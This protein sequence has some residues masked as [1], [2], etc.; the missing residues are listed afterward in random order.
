MLSN[1][2]STLALISTNSNAA[3]VPVNSRYLVTSFFKGWLT[4]TSAGGGTATW[5]FSLQPR[6]LMEARA[7]KIETP[8]NLMAVMIQT[9]NLLRAY[10]Q[11]GVDQAME[12]I[13]NTLL[14]RHNA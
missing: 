1:H 11:Y 5:T 10:T 3:V 6:M 9:P 13:E 8:N 4:M 14:F 2:P 12:S 7:A